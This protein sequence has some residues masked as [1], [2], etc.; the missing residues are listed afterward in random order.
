MN[1]EAD[2]PLDLA[3]LLTERDASY[4]WWMATTHHRTHKGLCLDFDHHAYMPAIIQDRSPII[5]IRKSTQ[6][7]MGEIETNERLRADYPAN[8]STG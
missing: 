4:D 6:C 1:S 5:D 7:G 2:S 8:S 3:T